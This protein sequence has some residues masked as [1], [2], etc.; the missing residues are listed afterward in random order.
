MLDYE[1]IVMDR[2]LFLLGGGGGGY[3]FCDL[4]RV[5]SMEEPY[6]QQ[7]GRYLVQI[8]HMIS[9]EEV[10]DQYSGGHAVWT[11]HIIN[12]EEGVQYMATD[13]AQGVVGGCIYLGK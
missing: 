5:F 11:C 7:G 10:H 9:M 12:T 2:P 6:H 3:H 8:C 13:T 1:L 4:Q